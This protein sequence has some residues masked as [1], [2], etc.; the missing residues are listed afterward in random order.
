MISN[1]TTQI[2]DA[3]RIQSS[4]AR[5]QHDTARHRTF[6][7]YGTARSRTFLQHDTARNRASVQYGTARSRTFLQHDT[8]RNRASVQHGTARNRTFVQHGTAR[9]R[10]FAICDT[11]SQ[12]NQPHQ[13]G[14]K[15]MT[16]QL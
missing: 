12:R 7:Q 13:E 11:E 16:F 8:A 2:D 9:N 6:V 14:D 4:S 1:Q 3:A 5:E 15:S 10:P